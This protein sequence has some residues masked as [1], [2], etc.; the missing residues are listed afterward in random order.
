M[1]K[2]LFFVLTLFTVCSLAFG[3]KKFS[4][5]TA[6][7]FATPSEA[8]DSSVDAVY[9]YD[10][11]E[12][13]VTA[14]TGLNIE[15]QVKVRMQIVTEKGKEYANKAVV[16][17]YNPKG[18]QADNDKIS[19][20]SAASYNLV[21]GKVVKT[22][23]S[24]KYEFKEQIDDHRMRLK[25]SIPEVK[26]GSIIEYKYTIISPRYSD[27]P[28]WYFQHS[29]PVRYS[30]Y[31][32]TF[33]EW[34]QYHV[35]E[36]G[37]SPLK[38]KLENTNI[39]VGSSLLKADRYIFEGENLRAFKN[40]K[41]IYCQDDYAQRVDFEL[42][43]VTIPGQ[44]YKDYARK[45]DDV[46]EYLKE[47]FDMGSY[48]KIKNPYAEEMKSLDLEGKSVAV[49]ASRIFGLLKSKLKWDKEYK[50]YCKNPLRILKDGKG[51]NIELNYIYMAML[52]DA[53][54]S[55][56]PMLIRRRSM[57]R[58]PLTYASID[59]LNTFVVAFVDENDALL[60]A[61]CS[62][63][64]GD[65]NILPADLM[66][67]GILYDP[68][69][70]KTPNNGATR[71]GTIYD[72]SEIGGN[73]TNTRINCLVTPDGQLA[74]QRINT[75]IGYNA[76]S[77]KNAYHEMEDSLAIIEKI[78]K[79]LDCKLSSFRTKNA[80]G[81]GRAVEERIRFSKE[82]VVDGD[83]IYFNP[84]VFADEKTNYFVQSDRVLP[85]EF[86][87]AQSTTITSVV[88]IPE[89][90]VV[91]EMP[92]PET[93]TLP[94]YLGVVISFEMQDNNLVTK[95]QSVV[96]NTFIPATEY[97]NLQEFWNKVLKINSMMVCLK[98]A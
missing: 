54:I 44:I 92:K 4:K 30:F 60:F 20:I 43:G 82:A 33:P 61:D 25:F 80:E 17:Y 69:V 53:G 89:G 86:P 32:A 42:K 34:F 2:R 52:R 3:Q 66:A 19:S 9:I 37:Y 68:N 10:I 28:T 47:E 59:K 16:F 75:H 18:A 93:V 7:D 96:G 77:Y 38:G 65:V 95:Y 49:K 48:L 91:E 71:G 85:V 11:G 70:T 62:A 81:V 45:W 50:L 67:E 78:E 90:Y 6:A 63:D 94:G 74:G 26:V 22:A 97:A 1:R 40:E 46:R 72:L 55:S 57:G 41:F 8:A 36:R 15:T 84:I 83:R 27:I 87:A 12:T 21:D 51:S 88:T 31:S 14:T 73:A 58:L 5:I 24:S 64:Y 56:T 23:M 29:E 35:E 13:R 76:L 79:N 39:M 98:K